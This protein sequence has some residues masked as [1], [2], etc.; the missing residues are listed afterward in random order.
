MNSG[1]NAQNLRAVWQGLSQDRR[2][3]GRGA[4][5]VFAAPTTG[6]GTSFVTRSMALIAAAQM[7]A[8]NFGDKQVLIVDMDIQSNAQ[9]NWFFSSEGQGQYGASEGPYDACYGAAPFWRVTP[10]MV[11]DAGQ[12][13]T[14]SH[15]MSLHVVSAANVAF[16]CFQWGQFRPGQTVHIQNARNYWH[17]LREYFGAIFVDTPALDRADIISTV[18]PE[19]DSTILVCGSKDAQSKSLGDAYGRINATGGRC[20]GVILND[21]PPQYS[22]YQGSA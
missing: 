3:D 11:D 10:S 16:T 17:R 19:A 12:N 13:L 15:F 2:A 22:D 1:S 6:I 14:D 5:Y 8:N 9:S 4:V 7:R 18:C 20:A 21:L